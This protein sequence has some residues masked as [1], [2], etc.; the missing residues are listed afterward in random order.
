MRPVIAGDFDISI[1][2]FDLPEGSRFDARQAEPLVRV[3]R[4]ISF[5]LL[6]AVL[7]AGVAFTGHYIGQNSAGQRNGVAVTPDRNWTANWANFASP[8]STILDKSPLLAPVS[9]RT[10]RGITMRPAIDQTVLAS[11]KGDFMLDQTVVTRPRLTTASLGQ[12]LV[13][14]PVWKLE[15]N[16]RMGLAEKRKIIAKRRV[17]LANSACLAR[18]VYF[19]ARSESELGQLAVAKVILNRV[20]NP[21]FPSSICDVVYQGASK[22]NSCQFSFACDGRADNPKIGKSWAQA[23]RVAARAIAGA[24]EVKVISTAVY[25]HADYVNPKWSS[26]MKRVIKIGRHIFYRDS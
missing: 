24:S 1:D 23:K 16:W 8:S 9:T 2:D 13:S 3:S 21:K 19:E 15:R 14:P 5:T 17:R 12:R 25:Y 20:A 6:G 11:A 10:L 7:V 26:A 4:L 22:K 18:A